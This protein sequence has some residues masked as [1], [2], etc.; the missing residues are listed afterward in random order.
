MSRGKRLCLHLPGRGYIDA[1]K[2]Q[3]SYTTKE[4]IC[5][6]NKSGF[7]PLHITANEVILAAAVGAAGEVDYMGYT[8]MVCQLCL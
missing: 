8:R 2:E 7:N 4:G 3:L 6:N 1:L 5:L